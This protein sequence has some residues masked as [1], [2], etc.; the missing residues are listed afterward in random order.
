MKFY[1]QDKQ[2]K[3]L[4]DNI[5]KGFKDGTFIEVGA[6][7]GVTFSNTLYFEENNNWTGVCVEANPIKFNDL[8]SNRTSSTNVNYAVCNSDGDKMDFICN[9]GYTS[10]I[11]G[12][13]STFHPRHKQRLER[14]I[15]SNG[16]SSSTITVDTIK[17]STICDQSNLSRVNLIS[18]DVEGAEFEVVKSL[19]YKDVFVDVIIFEDNYQDISQ[20]IVEFLNQKNFKVLKTGQ[21]IF[22]I[23]CDSKFL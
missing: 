6:W 2:D 14:E 9:T 13:V 15:Q 23:N 8:V 1:S 4:E 20:Q 21:D 17:L 12:L 3:Y 19:N 5:F 11:S 22:M 10:M 16:G 7:D 18:I